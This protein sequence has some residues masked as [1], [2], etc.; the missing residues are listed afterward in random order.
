MSLN[1]KDGEFI[2]IDKEL[3]WTSFDVVNKIRQ[4]IK[5]N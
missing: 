3:H 4:S 5:K 2:L 1:I